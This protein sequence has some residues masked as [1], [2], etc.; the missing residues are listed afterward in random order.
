MTVIKLIFILM[1]HVLIIALFVR[2]SLV[3]RELRH[4]EVPINHKTSMYCWYSFGGIIYFLHFFVYSKSLNEAIVLLF[5][6]EAQEYM[7]YMGTKKYL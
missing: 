7:A 3:L 1:M 2:N 4:K 6:T 5:F